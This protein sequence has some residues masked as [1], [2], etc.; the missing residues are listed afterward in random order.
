MTGPGH[1]HTGSNWLKAPV[2]RGNK[3]TGRPNQQGWLCRQHPGTVQQARQQRSHQAQYRG[4]QRSRHAIA[5]QQTQTIAAHPLPGQAHCRN[6]NQQGAGRGKWPGNSRPGGQ[7]Q[8]TRSDQPQ[9]S[10]QPT[11]G[12]RIGL[13]QRGRHQ[14]RQRSQ[15]S[16]AKQAGGIQMHVEKAQ[17]PPV[18]RPIRDQQ[19][20]RQG[21]KQA[22]QRGTVPTPAWVRA[23]QRQAYPRGNPVKQDGRSQQIA[24]RHRINQ[25]I[26]QH[27]LHGQNSDYPQCLDIAGQASHAGVDVTGARQHRDKIHHRREDQRHDADGKRQMR[28]RQRRTQPATASIALA[29][30]ER[31]LRLAVGITQPTTLKSITIAPGSRC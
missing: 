24:E 1:R 14:N 17:G 21:E 11:C 25:P 27:P 7:R 12:V 23:A 5:D 30:T 18:T 26:G 22:A 15:R 31:R 3:K 9:A 28:Y 8:R 20:R 2:T 10:A 29:M 19:Y 4:E 6:Q 16:Q 13:A